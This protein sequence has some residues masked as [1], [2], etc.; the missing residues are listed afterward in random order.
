MDIKTI[1]KILRCHRYDYEVCHEVEFETLKGETIKAVNNLY[2]NSLGETILFETISGRIFLMYHNQDCCESVYIEDICGD[3]DD[4]IGSPLLMAE[5]IDNDDSYS[6]PDKDGDASETWTFYKLAT[7]KGYVT[8][9]WYGSSNG[10]YSES[11]DFME[12]F[13]TD[14]KK[15]KN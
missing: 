5:E 9:R 7:E 12:F 13:E 4:L 15:L 1:N 11:V 8:I 2:D 3:L 14:L 6:L 10:Y